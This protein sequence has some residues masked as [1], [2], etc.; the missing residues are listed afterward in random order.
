M[1]LSRATENENET[2]AIAVAFALAETTPT[3]T[4]T[5][6]VTATGRES[7][8]GGGERDSRYSLGVKRRYAG[9]E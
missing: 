2:F 6:T 8:I 3:P 9:A 5:A 7:R 4:V 1:R